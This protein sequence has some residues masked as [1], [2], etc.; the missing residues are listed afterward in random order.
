MALWISMVPR[1]IRRLDDENFN[2]KKGFTV[3]GFPCAQFLNQ[4]PGNNDEIL[5]CLKYVR[6]GKR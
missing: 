1:V 3:L 5:D 2:L 6:P 4:E